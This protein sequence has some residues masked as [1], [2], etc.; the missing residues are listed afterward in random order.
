MV[1][2]ICPIC[3]RVMKS[4]HY[5][6]N[7]RKWIWRPYT[8]EV[9][10][11]LNERHPAQEQ[12][13]RHPDGQTEESILRS[14]QGTGNALD[15]AGWEPCRLSGEGRETCSY[16]HDHL[17]VTVAVIFVIGIILLKFGVDM[18]LED[19]KSVV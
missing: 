9:N 1:R 12:Y 13:E 18:S 19:R 16:F 11:Y 3:D 7:C 14:P 6:K 17:V 15:M 10:Y 4:A 5:C 2:N 8:Q